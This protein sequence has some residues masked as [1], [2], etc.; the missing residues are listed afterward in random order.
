MLY[1]RSHN[2]FRHLITS[3]E[4]VD[5]I[6]EYTALLSESDTLLLCYVLESR[7]WKKPMDITTRLLG[8]NLKDSVV[9]SPVPRDESMLL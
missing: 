7:H 2:D 6:Q 5:V 9:S 4:Q 1:S 3:T 8:I